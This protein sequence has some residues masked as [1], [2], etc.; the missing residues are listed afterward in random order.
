[1]QKSVSIFYNGHLF[2]GVE[3]STSTRQVARILRVQIPRL[4]GSCRA[5]RAPR[6]VGEVAVGHALVLRAEQ[7]PTHDV[8]LLVTVDDHCAAA[9]V[10]TRHKFTIRAFVVIAAARTVC[11]ARSTRM[12]SRTFPLLDISPLSQNRSI[13]LP[14]KSRRRTSPLPVIIP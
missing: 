6:E 14:I 3:S 9:H 7:K 8:E 2:D 4:V 11:A 13:P 5:H 1:M 12:G 10:V